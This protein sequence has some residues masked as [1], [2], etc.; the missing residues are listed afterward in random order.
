MCT[1]ES[2]MSPGFK[3]DGWLKILMPNRRFIKG[4]NKEI[5]DLLPLWIPDTKSCNWPG[6]QSWTLLLAPRVSHGG[7]KLILSAACLWEMFKCWL[8]LL[9]A[10]PKS[11]ARGNGANKIKQTLRVA[12]GK[13]GDSF[14]PK[15]I[16]ADSQ[17]DDFI[18]CRP[19]LYLTPWLYLS[20]AKVA[21]L[22][23]SET[24]SHFPFSLGEK[25]W[26]CA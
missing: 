16:I 17:C 20:C 7:F 21:Q 13:N 10:R 1:Q 4:L 19:V 18:F 15:T 3:T 14:V 22:L 23:L 12:G 5:S 8:W 24:H 26:K 6:W 11:Q 25:H 9:V 2:Q